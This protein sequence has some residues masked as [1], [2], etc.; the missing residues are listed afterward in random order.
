MRPRE[1]DARI[2]GLLLKTEAEDLAKTGWF[3][4]WQKR[5]FRFM[6]LR[7]YCYKIHI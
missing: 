7:G 5:V 1:K 6:L 4:R 2:D 3:S